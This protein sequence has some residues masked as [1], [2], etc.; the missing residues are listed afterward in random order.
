M[1]EI[2]DPRGKHLLG[3]AVRLLVQ[4]GATGASIADFI[5]EYSSILDATLAP[6][7][8]AAQPDTKAQMK[9]ALKEALLELAPPAQRARSDLR[10]RV[11]VYVAGAKTSLSLRKDM[12]ERTVEAIG[13]QRA[14]ELA[15]EFA[16]AKPDDVGNRSAWVDEQ[17]QHHLLLMKAE[18]NLAGKA[19]H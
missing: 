18:S 10:K 17:L 4:S 1:A 9:E 3:E 5:S 12:F 13:G 6:P 8:V 14:Q 19:P 15:Q 7:P 11:N 16:N 2:K